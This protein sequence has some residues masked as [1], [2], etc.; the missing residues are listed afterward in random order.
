MPNEK[1]LYRGV[2][3]KMEQMINDGEYPSG[4]R[5][6]PE[7]ELAE[8]FGVSRPTVRE[9]I[10]ALEALGRVEVKTGSGVYVKDA[11]KGSNG[12]DLSISPFELTE[13]RALIEG[14]AAA[15][16]ATMIT[17]EQLVELEKALQE[18]ADE[19]VDGELVSELADEKFHHIICSATQNGM[20]TSVID[21][22]WYVRDNSPA[23]RKAHQ[24]VCET[25]G[26]VRVREHQDIYDALKRRDAGAA[27]KAMHA[28]FSR[29]LNKLIAATES[30]QIEKIRQRTIESRQR[31]SLNHLSSED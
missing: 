15:L 19:S 1:R 30:E 12:I 25:D 18:M 2:M 24:A 6:P 13:A 11:K 14:E 27:R 21:E 4:G 5:L 9:A 10:I 22:L 20:L 28:H 7:R 17:D 31:Y 23:I 29:L 26:Q 3:D 16:A 8:R